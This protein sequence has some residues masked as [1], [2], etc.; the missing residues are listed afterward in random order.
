MRIIEN[1]T[2]DIDRTAG[3]ENLAE[4]VKRSLGIVSRQDLDKRA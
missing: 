1:L 3:F 4:M 2:D